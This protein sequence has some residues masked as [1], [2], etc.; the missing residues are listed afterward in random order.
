MTH[1]Y[2]R[3]A[4]GRSLGALLAPYRESEDVLV[5]GLPRGG[6]PVAAEVADTLRAPLDVMI[7]R[8][9]GAPG[10]P[11]LALGAVA[12]G[13]V[14]VINENVLSSFEDA[15]AVAVAAVIARERSELK[16]REALYRNDRLPLAVRDRTIIL[17]DDGAAT[18]ASMGAAVRATR[19]LGAKRIVAALPVASADAV[20]RLR[21]EADEVAC[22]LTPDTFRSV[23]EWY[24]R[25]EQ[26]SD[27]EVSALLARARVREHARRTGIRDEITNRAT[28]AGAEP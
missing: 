4:A 13:G 20:S 28:S 14:I 9:L 7:V 5:L 26:T 22:I 3:A 24:L 19:K 23:G 18:G 11:E 27:T 21:A 15:P 1:F 2:D 25:F 17:V 10:Q 6:V 16:R 12:S 8:K